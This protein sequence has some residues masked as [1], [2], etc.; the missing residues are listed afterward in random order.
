LHDVTWQ[1]YETFLNAVG[2]HRVRLTYDR[3]VLEIM[4]ISDPHEWW[5]IRFG[6]AITV[7]GTGL[8]TKVQG[9]GSATKRRQDLERGLEPDQSFYV[10]HA[11]SIHGPRV[12]DL[13]RDPPPDLT[14]EIDISRSSLDRLS[15]YAALGIPEVWCFDEQDLRIHVLGADGSYQV[16][17]QSPSFPALPVTDFLAFLRHTQDLSDA[18]F[19]TSCLEWVRQHVLPRLNP[20]GGS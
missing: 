20:G 12:I 8:G 6:L 5:K 15:V 18:E 14:V 9:Y 19:I 4:T 17:D 16:R 11:H 3:G 7:L 13:M 10:R 2:R 1:E